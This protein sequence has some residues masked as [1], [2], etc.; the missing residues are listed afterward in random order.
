M[1]DG[2]DATE[3]STAFYAYKPSL[4]GRPWEFRLTRD[5]L[6]WQIGRYQGRTPYASVARIRL[7]FRPVTMQTRRFVAEI[8]PIDGPRLVI[9][10]SS[11]KSIIEQEGQDRAYG[12]FIR[13]LHRRIAASGAR[14]AFETGSSAIRYWLGL[15]VFVIVSLGLAVLT[16]RAL[17]AAAWPAVAIIGGMLCLFVWQSGNYFR[18]NRPGRYRPEA[19]PEHV[20]PDARVSRY[21]L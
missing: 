18:R 13:E 7:S 11:W 21:F 9:A 5:A 19:L 4:M 6:E 10:S 1:Q 8:W 20:V 17:Q 3:P 14:V 15:A 16:V 2:T 12:A